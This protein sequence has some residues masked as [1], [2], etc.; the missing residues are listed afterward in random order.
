ML[1]DYLT[2]FEEARLT[3]ELVPKTCWFSNLRNRV[4]PKTWD[5]LR[6]E[7]AQQAQ[8][9]CKICGGQ[10]PRWPVECHEI[11]YYDDER[12]IQHLVGLTA[13]CP[14]CHEVKHIGL[15]GIR[16][17]AVIA[18]QHLATVNGWSNELAEIYIEYAFLIWQERSKYTWQLDL[19]WAHQRQISVDLRANLD[20]DELY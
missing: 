9:H 15:A 2:K 19:T 10:G 8:Q 18:K 16:G 17:R 5:K 7:T 13:L 3:I 20:I 14:A 1:P 11:W 6:R 4:A 12:Y